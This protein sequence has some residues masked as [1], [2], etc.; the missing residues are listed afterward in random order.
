MFQLKR[1]RWITLVKT[2]MKIYTQKLPTLRSTI[3]KIQ[4][5][6]SFGCVD[7]ETLWEFDFFFIIVDCWTDEKVRKDSN[8]KFEPRK[9]RCVACG[10]SWSMKLKL[11]LGNKKKYIKSRSVSSLICLLALNNSRVYLC[12]IRKIRKILMRFLLDLNLNHTQKKKF[13]MRKL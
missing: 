3:K 1:D 2:K 11:F 13:H 5:S 8:F 9:T 6:P 12:L 4:I 10:W 7:E